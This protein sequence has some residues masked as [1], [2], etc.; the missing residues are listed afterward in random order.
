[1]QENSVSTSVENATKQLRGRF[2]LVTRINRKSKYNIFITATSQSDKGDKK[3][4]RFNFFTFLRNI[5]RH[6]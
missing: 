2:V 6:Y 5:N 4:D 1:M 3:N